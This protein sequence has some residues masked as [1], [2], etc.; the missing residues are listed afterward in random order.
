MKK[1]V[2]IEETKEYLKLTEALCYF[3]NAA[4]TKEEL[5]A[6]TEKISEANSMIAKVRLLSIKMEQGTFADVE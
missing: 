1:D 4:N 3:Y 5:K 2:R 6:L